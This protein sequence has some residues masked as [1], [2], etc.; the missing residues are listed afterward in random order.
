MEQI[1]YSIIIPHK[2]IPEL[3]QRCLFS[4]PKRTDT[5]VIVIDDNSSS[6]NVSLMKQ[7]EKKI[8]L[9][10]SFIYDKSGKGAGRARNIGLDAAKGEKILFA[11]SD[12]FFNYCVDDI[13]SQYTNDDSDLLFFKANSVDTDFYTNSGRAEGLNYFIDSFLSRNDRGDYLLRYAHGAPHCKI[14]KRSL[15]EQNSVRFPEVSV[16]ED[17][18]FSYLLGYYAKTIKADKRALYCITMRSGSMTYTMN[19]RKVLDQ[20]RVM[21]ERDRFFLDHN[22]PL[23]RGFHIETLVKLRKEENDSVYNQCID[24]IMSYGFSR[25]EIEQRVNSLLFNENKHEFF[26]R[27]KKILRRK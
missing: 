18:R 25:K 9:N 10:V 11:D 21:A 26:Q 1:Q 12:D 16:N 4:I 8:D 17:T 22:I 6:D 20:V 3:L 7:M 5:E 27:I 2:N 19:E 13:L 23:C 14:I 15:I 24:I